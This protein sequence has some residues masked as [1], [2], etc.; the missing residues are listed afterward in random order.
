MQKSSEQFKVRPLTVDPL[1][2]K[3]QKA[4]VIS[5]RYM[6]FENDSFR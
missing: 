2:P 4:F 5:D 6:M 1:T 3:S